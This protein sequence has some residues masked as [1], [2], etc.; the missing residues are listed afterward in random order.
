MKENC[1]GD[2]VCSVRCS[3]PR[4][5]LEFAVCTAPLYVGGFCKKRGEIIRVS[6]RLAIPLPSVPSDLQPIPNTDDQDT[7]S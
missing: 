5:F 1:E 7:A 3:V 6:P 2:Q 4:H